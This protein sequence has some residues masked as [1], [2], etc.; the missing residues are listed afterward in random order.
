MPSNYR[1]NHIRFVAWLLDTVSCWLESVCL[2]NNFMPLM[3]ATMPFRNTW[4]NQAIPWLKCINNI[5]KF[6]AHQTDFNLVKFSSNR[7]R[8]RPFD[9]ALSMAKSNFSKQNV[10]ES[11]ASKLRKP[12]TIRRETR[13]RVFYHSIT[14]NRTRTNLHRFFPE[15]WC[16]ESVAPKSDRTIRIN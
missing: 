15:W 11:T 6:R 12:I 13:R 3:N 16:A 2:N 10:L 5:S 4:N 14:R 1:K 7:V 9:Q 8:R